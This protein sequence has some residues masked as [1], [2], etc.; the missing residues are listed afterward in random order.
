MSS[1]T[2]ADLGMCPAHA[3]SPHP[4]PPQDPILFLHTFSPK[5]ANVGGRHPLMGCCVLR[6]ILDPPLSKNNQQKCQ[7]I[8]K[9]HA[10]V[11][12]QLDGVR[13]P[14]KIG[15]S[16]SER[17][18]DIDLVLLLVLARH[19]LPRSVSLEYTVEVFPNSKFSS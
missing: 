7:E 11:S 16:Y 6:E 9:I 15:I 8:S 12:F 5:S 10:A 4:H 18:T 2:L 13:S 14:V 19:V 17:I 3:P 1:V